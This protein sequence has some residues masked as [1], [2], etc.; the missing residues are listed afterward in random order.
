MTLSQRAV[1]AAISLLA[2][3]C[4]KKP[5][6][7]AQ[8]ADSAAMANMPGMTKAGDTTKPEPL[9]GDKGAGVAGSLVVSAPQIA[10]GKI[11]WGA[12]TVGSAASTAA[13][14]G[15]LT[16][17]EDR[18]V[19]IGAPARG[20]IVTV[21]ANPGDHVRT[22]QTLVVIQ[23]PD[24]GTA[25]SDVAKATAMVTSRRAQAQYAKGA[26]DRAD[27]LLALKAIPKQDYDRAVADDELAQSE[28]HEADA[29]LRRART[30]AEQMGADGVTNGEIQIRAPFDGVVLSRSAVPGTFIEA[31]SLL[32]VVT[33]PARLWLTVSAPEQFAGLFRLGSAVRFVV[34]AYPDTFSARITAVGAGLDSGT[35]TLGVRASLDSRGDRLKPG[36]L[37]TAIVVGGSTGGA[38][39]VPEG[40]IQT[41]DGK[42]NV[43]I[44]HPDGKGG[45]RIERRE[46]EI[47]S[48]ANG[49]VAVLRGLAATDQVVTEGA[50]AV[51][52]AFLKGGMPKMEM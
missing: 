20:R 35:R 5:K 33:D 21:R 36:M 48:R 23:S 4:S 43:F 28:L 38:V 25:Q 2:A 15:Q 27:R 16:T 51:K 6:P 32:L 42:P 47:G 9:A 1:C 37:A 7:A 3:G 24:A 13:I 8:N 41:I 10:H 52:S 39:M 22:G 26:R 17:D 19:R 12:V 45:A 29:E 30:A 40:A 34:P 50:F 18:T 14:P 11:Q 31:G 46:V 49:K 44:V